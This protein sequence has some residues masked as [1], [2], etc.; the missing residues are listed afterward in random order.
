M[1]KG[2]SALGSI[3]PEMLPTGW[4]SISTKLKELIKAAEIHLTGELATKTYRYL[5]DSQLV[6]W[7]REVISY[8]PDSGYLYLVA[9]M[10]ALKS[11]EI[12]WELLGDIL[13]PRD[14]LRGGVLTGM[15]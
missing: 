15:L 6:W 7:E 1:S 8:N 10:S 2:V 12:Y 9:W 11:R 5:R 14:L 13:P 3:S 4:Y